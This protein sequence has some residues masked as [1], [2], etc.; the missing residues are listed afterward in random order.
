MSTRFDPYIET[1]IQDEIFNT[2]IPAVVMG[3]VSKSGDMSFYSNG[4][5]RWYRD[6]SITPQ[7]IFNIASMTKALT[8]VAALQLVE[9]NQKSLNL[10]IVLLFATC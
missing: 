8:S 3:K 6:D 4:P 9:Q 10:K 2:D 7:N 5:S 1:R